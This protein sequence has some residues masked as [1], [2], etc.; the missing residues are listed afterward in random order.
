[1]SQPAG[2]RLVER[3]RQILNDP[4]LIRTRHGYVLSA[5]AQSLRPLVANAL[6]AVTRVF[7]SEIFDPASTDGTFRIATTDYGAVTVLS[8][9]ITLATK[10]APHAC[11]R[12][13]P[14][15][16]ETFDAL[17]QG[18]L[19]MALYADSEL[20]ADFHYKTLFKDSYACLM[21]HGHP[22]A[23]SET[24][25]VDALSNWPRAVI[26]YP[27]GQQLLSD[28]I[29]SDRLN[30]CISGKGRTVKDD[31]GHVALR[32]PYFMSAPW[33]IA[34]SDLVMCVPMQVARRMAAITGLT[35]VALPQ[36]LG[37]FTYRLIW[38]ERAHRDPGQRWLRSLF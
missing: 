23:S 10:E 20:P 28:D 27:D 3:L 19:D 1:M 13:E 29:I 6:A 21:R 5:R 24:E 30:A 15:G 32:T 25:I 38:H 14:F 8:G 33:A 12:V 9:V 17:E 36:K 4:L 11:I 34:T 16:A 37:S 18:R 22:L 26:L 35:V 31:R 7:S 2:S